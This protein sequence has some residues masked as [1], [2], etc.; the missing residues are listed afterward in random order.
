MREPHV[1]RL[2]GPWLQ[3]TGRRV[4]LPSSWREAFGD[5][6]RALLAR[7]FNRPTNLDHD[8]KVYLRV[9]SPQS[10]ERVLLNGLELAGGEEILGRLEDANR[11][12]IDLAVRD[13]EA[14]VLDAWLEISEPS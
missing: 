4:K 3:D 12:V 10:V 7:H 6:D 11:L 8:A 13:H 2:R 5:S 14:D 1:I 9:T